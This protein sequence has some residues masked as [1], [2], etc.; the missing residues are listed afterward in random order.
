MFELDQ[1]VRADG[2]RRRFR[3]RLA[4]VTNAPRRPRAHG[5]DEERP[6]VVLHAH[7]EFSSDVAS[8]AVRVVPAVLTAVLLP[9]VAESAPPVALFAESPRRVDVPP[10]PLAAPPVLEGEPPLAWCPPLPV[11]RAVAPPAL[12]AVAPPVAPPT[13][14]MPPVAD[15]PPVAT[16][17]PVLVTPPDEALPPVAKV[18]PFDAPAVAAVP[19]DARLLPPPMFPV[20]PVPP[21][22]MGS[23]GVNCQ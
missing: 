19:P 7:P 20:P 4:N 14:P 6:L 16:V 5:D 2:A 9:S 11:P 3:R 18:P 13:L 22:E 15:L 8:F 12:D 23:F 1:R 17:P 21:V 10:V